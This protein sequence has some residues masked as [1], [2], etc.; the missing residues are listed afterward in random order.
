[1]KGKKDLQLN[2]ASIKLR[3]WLVCV[4]KAW[5]RWKWAILSE[6]DGIN[7]KIKDFFVSGLFMTS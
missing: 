4:Y 2:A 1:M 3:F 7:T 5:M 6:W